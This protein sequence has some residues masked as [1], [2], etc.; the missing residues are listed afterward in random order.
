MSYMAC[1]SLTR[2]TTRMNEKRRQI[3]ADS[4]RLSQLE[5]WD[6]SMT[7]RTG[8]SSCVV[9]HCYP[10]AKH[11]QSFTAP[12]R[13]DSRVW[14]ESVS[15]RHHQG[16]CTCNAAV[17][18][19]IRL[20][21]EARSTRVPW[22]AGDPVFCLP[23]HILLFRRHHQSTATTPQVTRGLQTTTQDIP[24]HPFTSE[25]FYL[26]YFLTFSVDLAIY[27]SLFTVN[28]SKQI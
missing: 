27:S 17:T 5:P 6:E 14:T 28:G 18:T 2:F 21:Y 26:T 13:A 20:R 25:H 16:S 22:V 12:L 7:R 9:R 24:V 1:V 23:G 10:V 8:E 11:W 3:A 15:A 19:M 4:C